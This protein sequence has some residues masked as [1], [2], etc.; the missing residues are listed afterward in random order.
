MRLI[1]A[2]LGPF[3]R[4]RRE[5]ALFG[6]MLYMGDRLKYWEGKAIFTPTS[7]KI[8]VF[9]DGSAEDDMEQQ[10]EFFRQLLRE[11]PG[12]REEVGKFLLGR[13]RETGHGGPIAS[14]W[15]EFR[16]SSLSIP[17]G[18][19]ERSEW[20]ISLARLSDPDHLWTVQMKGREPQGL[21]VG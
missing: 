6:S 10:H 13:A 9:V 4:P 8:E 5:D 15:E 2:V 16:V 19:L 3:K 12:L 18:S 1:D 7:S 11:W 20:E 14:L 21:E 17:K